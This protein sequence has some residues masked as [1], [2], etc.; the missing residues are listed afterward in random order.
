MAEVSPNQDK[1]RCRRKYRG[2]GDWDRGSGILQVGRSRPR[3]RET[4]DEMPIASWMQHESNNTYLLVPTD[5]TT[6]SNQR[7]AMKNW[8]ISCC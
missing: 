7:G 4:D 6:S 2:T 3:M 1:C 8:V 5:C